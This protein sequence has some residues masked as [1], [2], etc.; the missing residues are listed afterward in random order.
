LTPFTSPIIPGLLPFMQRIKAWLQELPS[1]TPARARAYFVIWMGLQLMFAAL[2]ANRFMQESVTKG[3]GKPVGQ[4]LTAFWAAAHMAILGHPGLA[5]N[6]GAIAAFEH[7]NVW[8]GSAA[9]SRFPFLYP[10]VY[11]LLIL[12]LGLVGYLPAMVGFLAS[13]YALLAACVRKLALPKAGWLA[14]VFSPAMLVNVLIGQNGAYTASCF[15]GAMLFLDRSPALGGACLGFLVCKPHLAIAVPLALMAA[16]RW[17]ALFA[18]GG[19][20]L[21]LCLMS[22]LV[23]GADS[24]VQFFHHARQTAAVLQDYSVEWPKMQGF[25]GAVHVLHGSNALAFVVYGVLALASAAVVVRVAMGRPGAGPEMATLAVASLLCTP[26]MFDYDLTCLLAPMGFIGT[27]ALRRG[28]LSWEK[29]ALLGLY[30]L[31]LVARLMTMQAGIPLVPPALVCALA[32]CARRALAPP[33]AA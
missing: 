5:Y 9:S 18:C 1:L 21:G 8:V 10:P 28:W 32:L 29:L 24:W 17:R 27:D 6:D 16:R 3:G 13:G 19:T 33:K 7:A 22:L 14:L 26:Y 4:D 31:P 25:F 15:A 11:L 23:F 2:M 12:P 20:A 30:A